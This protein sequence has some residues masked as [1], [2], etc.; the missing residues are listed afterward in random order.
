MQIKGTTIIGVSVDAETRCHHYYTEK[1]I[2][3][4]KFK[5]CDTYYPCHLCH[6]EK[7]DHPASQWEQNEREFKAILC[8]KCGHELTIKAYMASDSTCPNCHASF[9]PG[10]Q[11]HDHLYFK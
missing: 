8:G 9:N 2:I 6:E 1:D 10:C 4:I 3:A 11:L 7:A 5:C